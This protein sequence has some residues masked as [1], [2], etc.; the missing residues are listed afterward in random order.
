MNNA[1]V[2][3]IIPG[4]MDAQRDTPW[5]CNELMNSEWGAK[6]TPVKIARAMEH[7]HNFGIYESTG[8]NLIIVGFARVVSDENLFSSICD[9]IITEPKR[10]QGLGKQLLEHILKS[11][12][13]KGTECILHTT[14]ARAF[15]IKQGFTEFK[16][17]V[18]LRAHNP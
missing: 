2:Y 11:P 4:T 16:Q 8:G 13:V 18:L 17:G 5:I 3:N 15:Y 9:F 6:L 12:A 7:S 1:F 10:N 14:H